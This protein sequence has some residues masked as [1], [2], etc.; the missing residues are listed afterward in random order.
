MK[1]TKWKPYKGWEP[2]EPNFTGLPYTVWIDTAQNYLKERR[3]PP[4]VMAQINDDEYCF[5]VNFS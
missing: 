3:T 1:N 2:L 5:C 4:V